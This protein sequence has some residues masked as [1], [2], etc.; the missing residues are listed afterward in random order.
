VAEATLYLGEAFLATKDL[1]GARRELEAALG[2]SEKLTLV[3][4]AAN[5]HYWLGTILN[6]SGDS[7]GATRHFLEA[8]KLVDAMH[9]E[10]RTDDLLARDDLRRILSASPS[11]R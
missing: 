10:A 6:Q 8:R 7:A 1:A 9:K 3:P 11:S 2:L 4:L 5:A